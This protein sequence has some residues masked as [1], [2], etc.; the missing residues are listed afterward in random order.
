MGEFFVKQRVLFGARRDQ[1]QIWSRNDLPP[2]RGD[3]E[4]MADA[5]RHAYAELHHQLESDSGG[6]VKKGAVPS[7]MKILVTA[8]DSTV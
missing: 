7:I 1:L 2:V 4:A 5:P 3:Q 8:P 6:E